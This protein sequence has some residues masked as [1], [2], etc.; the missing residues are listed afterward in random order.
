MIV[1]FAALI[2]LTVVL[3]VAMVGLYGQM[4]ALEDKMR[5]LEVSHGIY[6]QAFLE[7][8]Q[9]RPRPPVWHEG[10]AALSHALRG[11]AI[12]ESRFDKIIRDVHLKMR[13]GGIE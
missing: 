4:R 7:L 3:F 8:A 5:R 11:A 13:D 2:T 6:R 12:D 9:A 1:A 10:Q